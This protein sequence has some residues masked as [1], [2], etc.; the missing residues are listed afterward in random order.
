MSY[1]VMSCPTLSMIPSDTA[2]WLPHFLQQNTDSP[3]RY[4]RKVRPMTLYS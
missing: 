3:A 1:I 4:T 2:K